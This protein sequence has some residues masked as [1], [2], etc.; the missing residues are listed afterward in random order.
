M[1]RILVADDEAAILEVMRLTCELDGHD[2][3]DART[4]EDA[5]A[6]YVD[7][8]PELMI[9]DVNMSF[10]GGARSILERLDTL[11]GTGSCPV[12]VVTGGLL[13]EETEGLADQERVL[14]V[15]QKPFQIQEL[16]D[17]ARASLEKGI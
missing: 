7:F 13:E 1:A 10:A 17:A 3:R 9:L 14:H 4:V 16:R 12:I 8:A 15:I 6:A 2:V 5:V 11:G